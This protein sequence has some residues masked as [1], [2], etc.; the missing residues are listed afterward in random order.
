MIKEHTVKSFKFLTASF[1]STVLLFSS[2]TILAQK[3]LIESIPDF[4]YLEKTT[5][6]GIVPVRGCYKQVGR[7]HCPITVELTALKLQSFLIPLIEEAESLNNEIRYSVIGTGFF[8]G[9]MAILMSKVKK[10]PRS[11]EIAIMTENATR[12]SKTFGVLGALF[13]GWNV[14][15]SLDKLTLYGLSEP[16]AKQLES[17]IV[18]SERT[19][20]EFTDFLNEHGKVIQAH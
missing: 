17:G 4:Y 9:G 8:L 14:L 18:S 7:L 20:I 11:F 5:E 10:A 1:L 2:P 16:L 12:T 15:V 13:L 6:D 3:E 19:L